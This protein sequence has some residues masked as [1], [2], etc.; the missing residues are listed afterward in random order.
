MDTAFNPELELDH[1]ERAALAL[2]ASEEGYKILHRII[3]SEVDKFVVDLI[4]ATGEDTAEVLEKHRISKVAAQLYEGWTRHVNHEIQNYSAAVQRLG[5]PI[6]PTEGMLDFGRV[7]SRD[8][9]ELSP[10]EGGNDD[11]Y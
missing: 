10:L 2:M 8:E 11:T 1:H 7:A 5:P 4:N 9:L 6:D 3:R